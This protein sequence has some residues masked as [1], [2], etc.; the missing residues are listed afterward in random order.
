MLS[1]GEMHLDG[2]Q[3]HAPPEDLD[4][5]IKFTAYFMMLSSAILYL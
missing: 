4:S 2:M 5:F 1:I 3:H